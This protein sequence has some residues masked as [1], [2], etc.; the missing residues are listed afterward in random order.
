[1]DL[2]KLNAAPNPENED[3]VNELRPID[4]QDEHSTLP[5][6]A[7]KKFNRP[8]RTED[9]STPVGLNA[10]PEIE[11]E[12]PVTQQSDLKNTVYQAIAAPPSESQASISSPKQEHEEDDNVPL[13]AQPG[14]IKKPA[15]SS[16]PESADSSSQ[17]THINSKDIKK[18]GI[19]GGSNS[20]K[21]Y[22][23]TAMVHLAGDSNKTGALAGYLDSK[24]IF[25]QSADELHGLR[26]RKGL[27]KHTKDY[28]SWTV[29]EP[30][31]KTQQKW[32]W[33]TLP[34]RTGLGFRG[35]ALEVEFLDAAGEALQQDSMSITEQKLYQ[36]AYLD[37][38][39]MVFCLPLWVAFPTD[40]LSDE[41]HQSRAKLLDS[42]HQVI[43]NYRTL[44]AGDN[45]IEKVRSILALTMA[46]DVRSSLVDLRDS[47]ITPYMSESNR[48][49][50]EKTLRK[51]SGVARY[52]ANARRVSELLRH[53]FDDAPI[54]VS[55][56]PNR[57][58]FGAGKPWLIPIS[59]IDGDV[60]KAP[61]AYKKTANTPYP[62]H[63]DLPLLVTLCASENA[64]M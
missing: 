62:V 64:L 1:M 12:Q 10:P 11:S 42:F 3:H 36:D 39:V 4:E 27:Y 52:L 54:D 48:R 56:I 33:L 2:Q 46:D 14:S 5:S 53:E 23:F 21:T 59:A 7:P 6:P 63:V 15:F 49:H 30:T 13:S 8:K 61:D 19:I 60:L 41:D 18:M 32:Y 31:L 51:P 35:K 44:F 17:P 20:G 9:Y 43:E 50:Y 57:L 28:A 34:Y 45:R 37:A 38:K 22:L 29:L 40:D 25:L 58:N 24:E 26:T 47:W 55:G 16:T